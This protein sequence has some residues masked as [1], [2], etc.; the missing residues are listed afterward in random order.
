VIPV[1]ITPAGAFVLEDDDPDKFAL[2]PERMPGQRN[3]FS[4]RWPYTEGLRL[5]EAMHPL[6]ILATG[7]YG[8]EL[9][10]QDGAPIRLVVPWK[11]GFKGIKSIVRITLAAAKPETTWNI[12]APDEY[13]F[14]ANVNPKHDHPRWSQ[15]TEQRIGRGHTR[16]LDVENRLGPVPQQ[17][18]Q[19]HRA[20][21]RRFL[22]QIF[23]RQQVPPARFLSV[24]TNA[25]PTRG[26]E[27]SI[28]EQLH[29]VHE[30]GGLSFFLD[31]LLGHRKAHFT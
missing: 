23:E 4:L 15:A 5:D 27:R 6:A 22:E 20:G 10:P 28:G 30:Q 7:L 16:C 17:Q 21:A 31:G 18:H 29:L 8:Q 13:G 26:L 24:Q 9:P 3:S 25:D 19:L 2:D 1:G 14:Y 12:S 11:Y